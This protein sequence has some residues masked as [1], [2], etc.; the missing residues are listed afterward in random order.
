M[1]YILHGIKN[2]DQPGIH[3]SD[4]IGELPIEDFAVYEI[5]QITQ[6]YRPL[7]IDTITG[8]IIVIMQDDSW[9][10][11]I[12]RLGTG[13]IMRYG[14]SVGFEDS[15]E[16]DPTG[17]MVYMF[18]YNNQPIIEYLNSFVNRVTLYITPNTVGYLDSDGYYYDATTGQRITIEQS[19]SI[20]IPT[21]ISSI[22][23]INGPTNIIAGFDRLGYLIWSTLSTGQ[24]MGYR[25]IRL[26]QSLHPFVLHDEHPNH[27]VE[28]RLDQMIQSHNN[29]DMYILL[30]TMHH[31]FI[32]GNIPYHYENVGYTNIIT[33]EIVDNIPNIE[34]IYV[35]DYS[36]SPTDE[37]CLIISSSIVGIGDAEV[38]T[39]S[40]DREQLLDGITINT[41][42]SQINVYSIANKGIL[43]TLF[44]AEYVPHI[45]LESSLIQL[46]SQLYSLPIPEVSSIAGYH[47][48]I[49]DIISIDN[50]VKYDIPI[51][52]QPYTKYPNNIVTYITSNNQ[53]LFTIYNKDAVRSV[54][55]QNR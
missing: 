4:D 1:F 11:E 38:Y 20:L 24:I 10:A 54:I 22:Y 41:E 47:R 8:T 52:L 25:S 5:L 3:W 15:H 49:P 40:N 21:V 18:S 36:A 2:D 50:I 32:A 17:I 29:W 45:P 12:R 43:Y 35:L 46:I 26:P 39:Y 28:K 42:E 48:S 13:D 37:I 19:D 53:K 33:G 51:Y 9:I 44:T 6:Q 30:S 27:I 14:R 16:R 23:Y 31:I 55:P 7:F 34:D